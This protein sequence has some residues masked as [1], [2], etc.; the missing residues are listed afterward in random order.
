MKTVLDRVQPSDVVLEPFPHIVVRG[1]LD[2]SHYRRLEATFPRLE[3]FLR[4]ES[5]PSNRRFNLNAI[6]LLALA[7]G[8]RAGGEELDPIWREHALAHTRPEFFRRVLELFAPHMRRVH[9]ELEAR[10]GAL[11]ALRP[12]VRFLDDYANADVLLD[13]TAVINTPVRDRATSVRRGHLD[14]PHKLYSGLFYMRHPRD[15][16]G[17]GDLELY[18]FRDGAPRGLRGSDVA[19]RHLVLAKTIRYERNVLVMYPNHLHAL[20][21]V[22]A[23]EPGPYPR[24]LLTFASDLARRHY[25]LDAYQDPM[26]VPATVENTGLAS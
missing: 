3:L 26:E 24:R 25:D 11:E 12:G 17:G 8:A 15:H 1:A 19:D 2:E 16:S 23:R 22:T 5:A 6:D 20:H 4:G 13:A 21:G 7:D 9:P 14:K 18:R 10:V